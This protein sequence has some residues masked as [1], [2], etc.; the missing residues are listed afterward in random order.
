[1]ASGLTLTPVDIRYSDAI[2]AP[3]SFA[4]CTYTPNAGYDENVRHICFNPKGRLKAGSL[5][6]NTD[7]EVSFRVRIK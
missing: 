5:E 4:A 1:M 2:T 3:A 6:T 7:F